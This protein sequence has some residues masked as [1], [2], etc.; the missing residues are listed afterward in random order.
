M[1]IKMKPGICSAATDTEST[2]Q[3][4]SVKLI[5]CIVTSIGFAI[6]AADVKIMEDLR[7][8]FASLEVD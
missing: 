3:E 1:T 5:G 2:A 4:V 8:R 7:I 6:Q